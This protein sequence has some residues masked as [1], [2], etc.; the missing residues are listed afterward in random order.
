MQGFFW[1][2]QSAACVKQHHYRA[3]RQTVVRDAEVVD[4]GKESLG[5]L[6]DKVIQTLA[7]ALLH[8]L[9]AHL[10]VHRQLLAELLVGFN[11][12]E[13]ADDRALVVGA[14]ATP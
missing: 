7:A 4:V 8:G 9:E 11:H 13:P 10:H 12:P 5:L 2:S 6:V 3:N 1:P 14:A